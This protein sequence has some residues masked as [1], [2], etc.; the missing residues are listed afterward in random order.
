MSSFV[1]KLGERHELSINLAHRA[2]IKTRTG[3]DLVELAHKPERLQALLE[4][5]QAE[6]DLLWEILSVL[7]GKPATALLAAAD[8]S[9]LEDASAAL[10]EAITDFFPASS[11]LR[12]PLENLWRQLQ[13]TRQQAAG[14]IEEQLTAAVNRLDIASVISVSALST[15]GSGEYQHSPQATG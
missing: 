10:L 5:L 15:S 9:T 6:D 13:R 1:D 2:R 4:A 7:T 11:P 8:G 12:R 14:A 3:W